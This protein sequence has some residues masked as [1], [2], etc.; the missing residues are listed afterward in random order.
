LEAEIP[1]AQHNSLANFS[2][3]ELIV[4]EMASVLGASI[5]K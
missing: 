1:N 5:E 2:A 4:V 3:L